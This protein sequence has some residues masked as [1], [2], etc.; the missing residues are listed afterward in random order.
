METTE[1]RGALAHIGEAHEPHVGQELELQQYGVLLA[2][3]A[4]LGEAGDLAGGGGEVL[5]APAAAA[6]AAGHVVLAGG[7]VVHDGTAVGVAQQR[8]PGTRSTTLSPSL[9]EQRLPW[10]FWPSPAAN[11]RL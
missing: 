11:L 9:P 5:V 3:Q 6:A 1:S 4:R 2:G 8:A 7:H 10:P